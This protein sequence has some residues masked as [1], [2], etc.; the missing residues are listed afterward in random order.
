MNQTKYAQNDAAIGRDV[1]TKP[2]TVASMLAR[3]RDVRGELFDRIVKLAT[4]MEE[5]GALAPAMPRSLETAVGGVGNQA[6]PDAPLVND[7]R[8]AVA[9]LEGAVCRVAEL[10][11]RIRV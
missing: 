4:D 1:A 3:L 9:H 10:H 6:S 2:A 5:R 11:E 8:E 7:I